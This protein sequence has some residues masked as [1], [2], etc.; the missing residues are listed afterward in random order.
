MIVTVERMSKHNQ[1]T[2][3][4]SEE[5]QRAA[6][7]HLTLAKQLTKEA[8]Y[9]PLPVTVHCLILISKSDPTTD[10]TGY[11]FKIVRTIGYLFLFIDYKPNLSRGNRI[12]N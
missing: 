7:A 12:T 2:G 9:W 4:K 6:R 1:M 3:R 5:Q 10:I 8:R 11:K